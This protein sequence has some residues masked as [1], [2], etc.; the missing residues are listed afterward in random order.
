[1]IFE[2]GKHPLWVF[3]FII[4][5]KSRINLLLFFNTNK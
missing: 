5:I 2:L 3:S 1:M 4:T